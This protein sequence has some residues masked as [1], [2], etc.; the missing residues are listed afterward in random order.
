MIQTAGVNGLTI[1]PLTESITRQRLRAIVNRRGQLRL[2]TGT[3]VNG[4]T[5][6]ERKKRRSVARSK[7][8][9][10]RMKAEQAHADRRG[11]GKENGRSGHD[12]SMG[13]G[14]FATDWM[15]DWGMKESAGGIVA[16]GTKDPVSLVNGRH[17][18]ERKKND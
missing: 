10:R 4:R 17:R 3:D 6:K 7:A 8:E 2:V 9:G 13:T 15:G 5:V 16:Q 12:G 1:A 18:R 11:K 14:R